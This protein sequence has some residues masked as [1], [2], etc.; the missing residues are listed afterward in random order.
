MA[1]YRVCIDKSSSSIHHNSF[2]YDNFRVV[3]LQLLVYL[4]GSGLAFVDKKRMTF[5]TDDI[6]N[7]EL[8][9]LVSEF[10]YERNV[11]LMAKKIKK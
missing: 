3:G 7:E 2:A 5:S 9:N 11:P 10:G 1:K 4:D 6:N 8:E